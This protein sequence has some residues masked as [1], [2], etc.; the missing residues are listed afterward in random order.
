MIPGAPAILDRLRASGKNMSN[1]MIAVYSCNLILP[2][3][4]IIDAYILLR[5]N[6]MIYTATLMHI[7]IGMLISLPNQ[8]LYTKLEQA[9]R[10]RT[11]ALNPPK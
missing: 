8:M 11:N 9:N 4:L 1:C 2:M 3:P 10:R 6:M 5:L 7:L